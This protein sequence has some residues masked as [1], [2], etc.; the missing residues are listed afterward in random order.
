MDVE[1]SLIAS[2]IRSQAIERAS[3]RVLPE[4]FLG[5]AFGNPGEPGFVPAPSEVWQWM[6]DHV[7]HYRS[8]PSYNLFALRFPTFALPEVTD[9]L[10][11]ILDQFLAEVNRRELQKKVYYLAEVCQDPVRVRRAGEILFEVAREFGRLVPEEEVDR[12]SDSMIRY[13]LYKKRQEMGGTPGIT[14]L[15][16]QLNDLTYGVQSH[17]MAVIT[18]FLG[19]GKSTLAVG[20]ASDE[21]FKRDKTGLYFSLEMQ[22]EK[23]NNKWDAF[24]SKFK[25]SK[26]KR[27]ALTEEEL[28]RWHDWALKAQASKFEKD[29]IVVSKTDNITIDQIYNN[30]ERYQPDFFIVDSVDEVQAPKALKSVWERQAWVAREIKAICRVTDTPCIALAQA[31][32]EAADTGPTLTTLANSID[33]GRKADIVV[34]LHATDQMKKQRKMQMRALKTR[35]D[36]GLGMFWDMYWNVG[37]LEFREWRPGDEM[38]TQSP[39]GTAMDSSNVFA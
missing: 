36:E 3:S 34:G 29:V 18:A 38:P 30:V 32:R 23:L 6:V 37:E 28:D 25:Y 16:Q 13:E 5:K 10:D 15:L 2:C 27:G 22:G 7:R 11:A 17:E 35:D 4:H 39:E 19:K 1:R 14:L 31:G 24:A 21:Y 12:L 20:I 8:V 33:I 9:V 26:I